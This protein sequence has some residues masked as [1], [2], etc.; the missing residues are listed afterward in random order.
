[1]SDSKDLTRDE[2]LALERGERTTYEELQAAKDMIK[3]HESYIS[4]LEAENATLTLL[5]SQAT[6]QMLTM[7]NRIHELEAENARL[8]RALDVLYK[9]LTDDDLCPPSPWGDNCMDDGS[10]CITCWREYALRG[11]K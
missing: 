4:S 8:N 10:N 7:Q 6:D 5:H 11:E 3:A 2:I 9:A 1:M